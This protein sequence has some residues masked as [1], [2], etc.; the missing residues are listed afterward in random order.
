MLFNSLEFVLFFPAVFLLYYALPHKARWVL[1]LLASWIFYATFEI[2]YIFLILT[3]TITGYVSG[4]LIFRTDSMKIKKLLLIAN[5]SLTLGLLI[6]FKYF[7]LF[8]QSLNDLFEYAGTGVSIPVLNILLPI[9][10]SFYT[11]QV[12]GY[13][14]DVYW[15][16]I[17]PERHAGIF[18][19]YVSF[20]PQLVAGPIERADR[21]I[22]QFYQK[23]TFDYDRIK[24]GF[25]L[26]L[27]GFFQKIAIADRIALVVDPVFASP[28]KF[29]GM[30]L[31]VTAVLFAFQLY[32]D[33]A[34]YTN[35]ALGT[36]R[37]LGFDL[38]DNFNKPFRAKN[39]SEFWRRWHI[40]LS[41]WARDYLYLPITFG[42]RNWGQW[43]TVYAVVI[44]FV[45]IG[46]W[47]GA[48]WSYLFFGLSMGVAFYYE[49]QTTDFRL[50]LASRT[51]KWL[52]N[53]ASVLLT[54]GYICI[55]FVFFRVETVADGFNYFRLAFINFNLEWIPV[56]A[57]K[58]EMLVLF[59]CIAL[60]ELVHRLQKDQKLYDWMAGKHVA[61]RW[62][63]YILL[64]LIILNFGA[65]TENQF[66]YF[67]F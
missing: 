27:W 17:Q 11:F 5:L 56:R 46:I 55:L 10:I 39:V 61:V 15:G 58:W 32:C 30:Q 29:G 62:S 21:L 6:Y 1:L 12:I 22:P 9:G 54:F 23:H 43:A 53:G 60:V 38:M 13:T 16:K 3:T 47:H 64:M 14:L 49:L 44:T 19:L 24:K 37:M 52:Y 48:K 26:V 63:F 45:F 67:Q 2:N 42:R 51:P 66:I 8:A 33:F 36:A 4:L 57:D 59:F 40:S 31:L 28:E 35:I 18:A 41:S 65:F 7:N 34:G 25:I 20:F 50:R